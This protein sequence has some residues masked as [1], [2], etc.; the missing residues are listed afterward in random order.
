MDGALE[1][2]SARRAVVGGFD[3][4]LEQLV[5][6]RCWKRAVRWWRCWRGWWLMLA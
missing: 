2:V 6:L 1:Q 4:L 5:L 3:S